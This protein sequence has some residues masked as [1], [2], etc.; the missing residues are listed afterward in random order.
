MPDPEVDVR[1]V[2]SDLCAVSPSPEVAERLRSDPR[3]GVRP[4]HPGLDDG[5]IVPPPSGMAEWAV[6]PRARLAGTVRLV[7]VLVEFPDQEMTHTAQHFNDLFFSLDVLP[8][9][10]VRE[11]F[12]EVSGGRVDLVGQTVGSFQLPQ[13]LAWYANGNYGLGSPGEP[14]RAPDMARDTVAAADPAVD[15]ATYDNDGDGYVEGFVIVHAGPGGEST[16]NRGHIWSHKWALPSVYPADMTKVYGY[17]TVPEDARVGVCAHELG[18]LLFGFPDLYDTDKTSEGLGDWCLM[19]AGSW[20][21]QGDIPVHPSAWCKVS[22]GW[23]TVTNVTTD[24]RLSLPDVKSSGEVHRLWTDGL[25]GPEYFL[26]ENRQR[27]GFDQS[28][29]DDGLL[30]WHVDESRPDNTDENHYKVALLQADG[31]LKLTGQP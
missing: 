6:P 30:I 19:A 17:L 2:W 21:G 28:L 3:L 16:G 22:Q 24:G 12:R 18:H 20:G 26:L 1:A 7:V 31:Y 15:F 10:S 8:N 9:G 4:R 29:P 25:S 14:G 11:Y 27:T 5:T 13:T 23:V